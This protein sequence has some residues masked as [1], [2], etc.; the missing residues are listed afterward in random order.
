MSSDT[1]T[2]E[3]TARFAR[4]LF[5]SEDSSFCVGL[6]ENAEEGAQEYDY[7]TMV[8]SNL[9]ELHFPVTYSGEWKNDPKYGR[10][11]VVEWIVSQLPSSTED[12]EEFVTSMK[13]GIGKK[14]V[15]KMVEL[16]GPEH[17]WDALNNDP[18][19]FL[20]VSGI[21]KETIEK[22][23]Y[24]VNALSYQRE[25]LQ[26]FNGDLKLS[27]PRY[28]RL[29]SLYNGRLDEMLPE[30][31]NNPFLLQQIGIPFSELDF[32]CARNSGYAVND[33]RRLTAATIQVL[34]DAQGQSHVG[35][36]EAMMATRLRALLSHFGAIS[37]AECQMF[38]DELL[39][40]RF[41]TK[42]NG[43]YYLTRA[44]NEEQFVAKSI[45]QKL[46]AEKRPLDRE[47]VEKA[48][49]KYGKQRKDDKGNP[50][51]IT[52]ADGQKDA[53]YTALTNRF[54]V[55]TGGPGTG[56]STILDAILFCWKKFYKEDDWQLMAPTGKAA[57]RMTEATG[58]PAGTIH[59]ALGLGVSELPLDPDTLFM[60]PNAIEQGLV[61][62]DESSMIDLSVTAALLKAIRNPKQHLILVGDPN[63]LPSVGY[64]NVL[65]DLINSQVVP[66]A[67]LTAIYRQAAGNPIIVNSA[68]MRD[69]DVSLDFSHNFFK[70]YNQGSDE[71]N[72]ERACKYFMQCVNKL[73]I[74]NVVMLSPYHKKGAIST[75]S[76]N[77]RL[78]D[79]FNPD[80]GQPSV[81]GFGQ[82]LRFGDRVMQLKNTE[83]AVNGDVGTIQSVNPGADI[84]EPCVVVKFDNTNIIKEYTKDELAQLELAYA[85][86]VHKSQGSQYR[87]VVMMLPYEHSAFLRRDLVYTGITRASKYV[88]IFGPM[89]TLQHAILNAN[90]DK[91]YTALVPLIQGK[92]PVAA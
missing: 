87:C 62:V 17:F 49:E 71:A 7:I 19:V 86:S 11:F 45:L 36:P 73:G 5:R 21:T 30:L 68:K 57:V 40:S 26:F 33:N 28:K 58:Q 65:A 70:G 51:P 20:K 47:K 77:K 84:D 35:L 2:V 8:G 89:H 46:T 43:M 61:V 82:V 38:L 80:H 34:L 74:K 63:Q 83:L 56:K 76:L 60:H 10:Q 14:R 18:K 69:G 22:L 67:K 50:A 90:L 88:A 79:Y 81:K 66:V 72:M 3:I 75:D 25:L 48:L 54:C 39:N 6:Y 9:P 59:S 55:I 32:F 1:T 92:Y 31:R 42:A 37:L 64:G 78:Q 44:Y 52:L 91:R 4:R 24:N 53:V 12:M 27:G 29:T 85:L 16:V 15:R 41:V 23:Q 13:V